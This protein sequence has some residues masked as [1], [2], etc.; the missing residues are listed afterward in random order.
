MLTVMPLN[1]IAAQRTRSGFTRSELARRAGVLPSVIT[2]AE[3][4]TS[5]PRIETLQ[6]IARALNL[7]VDDL[8]V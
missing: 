6:K 1:R 2:R 5:S 8:L 3:N 7:R 4:P